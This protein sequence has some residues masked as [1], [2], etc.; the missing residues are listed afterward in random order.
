MPR[1]DGTGP[2]GLGPMTGRAAGFCAGFDAPGYANNLPR[3]RLGLGRGFGRGRGFRRRQTFYPQAVPNPRIQR[4]Q[5]DQQD[6]Q[7]FAPSS[8]IASGDVSEASIDQEIQ[9][10]ENQLDYLEEQIS[11]IKGRLD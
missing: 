4:P 11:Q 2:R 5:Q 3:A 10:L 6:G 8:N 9:V 7:Q 1:G